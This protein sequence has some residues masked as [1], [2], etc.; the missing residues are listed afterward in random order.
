MRKKVSDAELSKAQELMKAQME[1][2]KNMQ[3]VKN[4]LN[5]RIFIRKMMII[6]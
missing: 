1:F 3:E 5:N 6:V 2:E 4:C